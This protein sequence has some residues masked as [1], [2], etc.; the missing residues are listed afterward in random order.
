MPYCRKCGAKLDDDAQFCRVCGSSVQGATLTHPPPST[1]Y[2]MRRRRILP[3]PVVILIVILAFALFFAA[4]VWA[5]F[6]PVNSNVARAATAG[7]S[8]RAVNLDFSADVA[9][10]NVILRTLPNQLVALNV[11]ASGYVGLLGDASN[12]VQVT[13]TNQTEGTALTVTSGVSRTQAWPFSSNLQVTCDVYVDPSVSLSLN[14]HTSV[15]QV[16]MDANREV[17]FDA[18]TLQSGTGSVELTLGEGTTLKGNIAATATTGSVQFVWTNCAVIGNITANIGSVTGS[19]NAN[20]TQDRPLSGDVFFDAGTSTGSIDLRMDISGRVG[21]EIT[22]NT[23]V[24]SVSIDVQNF[25][26][27]KSPIY[28]SNFPAEGNFIANLGA[29]T[30]SIHVAASY[31]GS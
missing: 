24:G 5:P 31:H 9:D 22:S 21:S 4:L 17:V 27:N 16:T 7:L 30:G 25:N 20:V 15:G 13:F 23:S 14:I 18:L 1:G 8:V 29:S 12:P 26:G 2:A 28:S 3:I 19:L 11:T 10:V 6:V